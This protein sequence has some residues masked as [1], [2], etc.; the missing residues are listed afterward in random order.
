MNILVTDSTYKNSLGIVRSLG[1]KGLKPFVLSYKKYSLTS[2][3]RF[4]KK[5]IVVPKYEDKNFKRVFFNSLLK[6]KISLIILVGSNSF[7][8]I[9]PL[10]ERLEKLGI[11][12]ITVNYK[13]INIAFSKKKTYDLAQK[14]SI[15]I[16]KTIYPKKIDTLKIIKKK[17]DY[18]CVI[19]GLFEVGGNIV[20]YA[21]NEDELEE[22]YYKICKKHNLFKSS[23]LPMIQEYIKGYG[24]AFFAVYNKGNCGL[25]FQHKRLRE[26]PV[27][28]GA[29]VCAESFNNLLVEKYGKLILDNLNWHGVAMVEFKMN[30]SE[31]PILMEINPK[32]WGSLDLALEAGVNFPFAL[33]DIQLGNIVNYKNNFK[34]PLRYHWPFHGDLLH[35]FDKP[36]SFFKVISDCFNYKVKSNIWYSDFKPTIIMFGSFIFSFIKKFIKRLKIV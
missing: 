26:M 23:N 4:C 19:K 24:C 18:P 7:K 29:S 13:T 10:K 21:Y 9:V 36:S 8:K 32:F 2:F 22:K 33:V 14:L 30:D 12:I 34:L 25:T 20:D 27:T 6:H 28:G 11:N 35:A 5:E 15:P 16:P 31:I 17:I 3:S 1:L